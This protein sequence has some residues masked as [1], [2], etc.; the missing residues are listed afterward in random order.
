MP[1][2]LG[3]GKWELLHFLLN[4]LPKTEIPQNYKAS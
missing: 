4:F 3:V 1:G 2:A